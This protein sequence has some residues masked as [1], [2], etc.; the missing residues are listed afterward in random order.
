MDA[1]E[2]PSQEGSFRVPTAT[3]V[4]RARDGHGDA[5]NAI[6]DR[7]RP[8]LVRWTRGRLPGYAR[9]MADTEDLV[10]DVMVAALARIAS[11]EAQQG[12]LLRYL[13]T[14]I[15]NRVRTNI[16]D[17]ANRQKK[18]DREYG[19][20]AEG[21]SPFDAFVTRENQA[22]YERGLSRLTPEEQDL[23][24]GRIEL[25]MSYEELAIHAGKPSADAARMACKRAIEKLAK[26]MAG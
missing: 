12:G 7:F 13:Q 6:C 8:R 21:K 22:K 11:I 24:V 20:P 18:L 3:L 5:V 1:M 2:L 25:R 17:F 10:Q 4:V 9:G 14:S 16:R 15:L 26:S 19:G 23:V